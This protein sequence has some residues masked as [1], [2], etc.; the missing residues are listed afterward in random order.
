MSAIPLFL[1]RVGIVLTWED[2][3]ERRSSLEETRATLRER[4]LYTLL[5]FGCHWKALVSPPDQ[6]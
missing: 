4:H 6:V 1:S 3:H 2:I 5:A